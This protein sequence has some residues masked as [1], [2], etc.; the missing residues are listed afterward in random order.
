MTNEKRS[1]AIRQQIG[2]KPHQETGKDTRTYQVIPRQREII[3]RLL[4]DGKRVKTPVGIL[5]TGQR[6]CDGKR[7]LYRAMK[8]VDHSLRRAR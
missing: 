4:V 8:R 1:R 2:Y 6:V 7:G 5:H 3:R